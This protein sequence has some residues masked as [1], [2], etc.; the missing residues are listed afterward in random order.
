MVLG[1]QVDLGYIGATLVVT[2]VG[3]TAATAN[4]AF[5]LVSFAGLGLVMGGGYYVEEGQNYLYDKLNID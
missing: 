4:L 2:G 5:L 3:A 1:A